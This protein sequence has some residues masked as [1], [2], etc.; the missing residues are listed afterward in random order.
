MAILSQFLCTNLHLFFHTSLF[1]PHHEK[2]CFMPYANNK[3]ADQPARM[4]SLIRAFVVCCLYSI[5]P[6]LAKSK[7]FKTLA[8]L[9]SWAGWFES[10]LV[11]NPEDRFSRDLAYFGPNVMSTGYQQHETKTTANKK[12][13]NKMTPV[14]YVIQSGAMIHVYSK[15]H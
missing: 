10:Y 2:T 14:S 13:L 5:I 7:K 1:Q 9:C 8:S 11:A 3:G 12:W 6:I 15:E 4:R